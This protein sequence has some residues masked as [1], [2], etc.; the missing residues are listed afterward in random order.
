MRGKLKLLTPLTNSRQ[1]LVCEIYADFREE[2][3]E[4]KD[5]DVNITIK[6]D[7]QKR[8]LNANN[9]MWVLCDK[10]ASKIDSTPEAVYR[11]NVE[12]VGVRE[13][14]Q[15]TKRAGTL[16]EK[17]W[18][19]NGVGWFTKVISQDNES[20]NLCLYYGSSSYNTKQ[21]SRLVD[22]VVQDAK[23]LGITTETPEELARLCNEWH[24][25]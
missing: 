7:R 13:Y 20:I 12:E 6:K 25:Y 22:A 11:H 16:L 1:Q 17:T 9:Y 21:M 4:L 10:I 24:P 5:C 18:C 23:A 2:Y 19:N 15:V 3:D 8:T 14:I